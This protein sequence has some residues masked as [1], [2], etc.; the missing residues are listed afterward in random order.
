VAITKVQ[1][2]TGNGATIQLTGVTTT[3]LLTLQESVFST[4]LNTPTD[5][6][7]TW[8]EAL[9]PAPGGNGAGSENAAIWY[10][11]NV[12][13]GTHTVTPTGGSSQ[14]VLAEWSGMQTTGVLDKVNSNTIASSSHT[15]NSPG[16]TGTLGNSEELILISLSI[17]ESG[18]FSN[19]GITDPVT[20][21]YTTM[22]VSQNDAIDIGTMHAFKTVSTADPITPSFGWTNTSSSQGSQ[23]VVVT[24]RGVDAT[25]PT[26]TAATGT[27]TGSM[28]ATVGATTDEGNGTMYAVVTTSS[29]QPSVAQIKAGQDH[30][31]AAATWAGNQAIDSAGAK[32]FTATGLIQSTNYWAHLVH[33]D[34]AAND[35]NRVSSA[36][37]TTSAHGFVTTGTGPRSVPLP[38]GG[39]TGAGT[40]GQVT[41]STVSGGGTPA[42]LSQEQDSAFSLG[43]ARPTGL[44]SESDTALALGKVSIRA[45]GLA[46]E[47]DSA[48]TLGSARPVGLAAESDTALP[49]ASARPTGLSAE[50]DSALALT[51]A[52]IKAVGLASESDTALA[53]SAVQIRA[54]GLASESDTALALS[55]GAGNAVG[56]AEEQDTALALAG[57]QIRAVGLAT[58]SNAALALS[59]VQVRDVGIASESDT[60]FALAAVQ[61]LL[62]G[63]AQEQDTA[64]ALLLGGTAA[65]GLA[66]EIDEAFALTGINLGGPPVDTGGGGGGGH[67]GWRRHRRAQELLELL[68]EERDST[69]MVAIQ[70]VIPAQVPEE[71][72]GELVD[73]LANRAE[74]STKSTKLWLNRV[75]T[76]VAR[77]QQEQADDEEA[78]VV[79]LLL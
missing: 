5:T 59:P 60:A 46:T 61:S 20:G 57:V 53:L 32:T 21:S 47:N 38:G 70:A 68:V 49:L 52:Q 77:L 73:L 17:A 26:L 44:A 19:L 58:E 56:L 62:T 54:V 3:N 16:S 33:T 4:D 28:N 1:S 55:V 66:E 48:L 25:P 9:A 76:L 29:T 42:G 69:P 6:Q 79:M 64:L 27:A 41:Q 8:S 23:A 18:G 39:P 36:Q 50:N 45:T 2:V 65:V 72:L 43:S 35:S 71:T 10:Q 31:G 74:D 13:S 14:K 63:L 75:K 34:A 15:S 40:S 78:A 24:F 37:F 51:A 7:G 11:A 22:L 12:A 30:T 67:V